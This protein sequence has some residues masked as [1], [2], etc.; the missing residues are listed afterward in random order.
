MQIYLK[1]KIGNPNLFTGR[2]EEL[3]SLLK[4]VDNIKPEFSKSTAI[5]S[6]RKTG[7]SALLQRLYNL[8]FHKN[9]RVIPFYYQIKEYDQWLIDFSK[10]F[11]LNF[12][13]QYIAFKSR[14]KEYL[15]LESKKS[16]NTARKIVLNEGY[17]YLLEYIDI[18]EEC[19]NGENSDIWD[20]VRDF[21]RN[22]AA[23]QDE[24]IVQIIDEFQY[25]SQ[26][27]YEDKEKTRL[28]HSLSGS[29][30]HTAEYKNAPL[31]ISGSWIGWLMRELGTHLHGRF[32]KDYL[33]D[34]PE[35]EALEM[36]FK[37][38][39]YLNI[40]I[41]EDVAY[42]IYNLT[43][44]NPFYI[45]SL[46]YSGY[47]KK[48]LTTEQ[49]LYNTLEYES[50]DE[51]G[52]I[53]STWMEYLTYAF[54]EVNGDNNDLAKNIVLYLC[55]N[56]D[57]EVSRKELAEKLNITLSKSDLEKRMQ[58]LIRSDII[59]KGR[60][61][62]YYKAISDHIFDK[63]FRG[64]YA[65]EITTFDPKEITNEYK[66]LF[67]QWRSRFYKTSGEYSRFK[68]IVAEYMVCNHLKYR[69]YK[70]NDL[71]CSLMQNLPADFCFVEYKTVW[72]Y[73]ASPI[74][75]KNIEIDVFAQ[76]QPQKN[77]YSLIGEVKNRKE[78]FALSEAEFFLKKANQLIEL[79]NVGKSVLFV[80]CVGGF[81]PDSIEFFKEHG[82]AWSEDVT[83]L[84]NNN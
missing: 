19:V 70:N 78:P 53:N 60:S 21:P 30:F 44:G 10:D 62:F 69:A 56:K 39:H 11:F 64:Q 2:K 71:F 75:D 24:R 57:R 23:L 33:D 5:L 4:W 65:D 72:K 50:Q 1:E 29:Y 41:N 49:G 35:N 16:L 63:V 34:M 76:I 3:D 25:I 73:T 46:F 84:N 42:K 43:K 52:S 58:S 38:S 18:V 51:R 9:D 61:L 22:I 13:Y 81:R 77:D 55:Q 36:I 14:K 15:S 8:V 7:K 17:E 80:I 83:W 37:Y 47:K 12:L 74:E 54:S 68:G 45:S 28:F 40:P 48:D 32:N 27:I 79:E 6:R 59:Q 67:E 26:Y 66:A 20:I 82:M 31:L